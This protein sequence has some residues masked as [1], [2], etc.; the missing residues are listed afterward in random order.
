MRSTV[1]I[2]SV[3]PSTGVARIW[4]M[5]VAY[6]LQTKSG[7]FIQFSPGAR[8]VCTVTMKLTPVRMELNPTMNAPRRIGATCV[9]E[10][11]EYGV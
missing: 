7:S 2:S 11:L 3:I 10:V 4:M 6:V 9:G 1:T 8:R 5:L